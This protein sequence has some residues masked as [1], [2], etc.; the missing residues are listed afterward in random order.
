MFFSG[1]GLSV[2]RWEDSLGMGTAAV[3]G[4]GYAYMNSNILH[5]PS[6]MSYFLEDINA[7]IYHAHFLFSIQTIGSGTSFVAGCTYVSFRNRCLW[8]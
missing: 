6:Y 4:W 3:V 7:L 1:S 5:A 2:R 8:W